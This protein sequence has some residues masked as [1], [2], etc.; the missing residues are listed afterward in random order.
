MK[1]ISPKVLMINTAD[2]RGGAASAA[3]DLGQKLKQSGWTIKW[4]VRTKDS[5]S[6]DVESI[7][8]PLETFFNRLRSFVL[9]D[10]INYGVSSKIIDHSWYRQANIVHFHNLHGNYLRLSLIADISREKP[11]I[12]T[13]HDMWAVTGKDPYLYPKSKNIF[14]YPP[15]LWPNK[16]KLLQ[17]KRFIYKQLANLTIVTPSY[18]L[19][20]EVINSKVFPDYIP[21]YTIHNGVD[22]DL[23]KPAESN[24]IRDNFSISKSKRIILF[25]AQGGFSNKRKGGDI[26]FQMLKFLNKRKDVF[27]VVVG[28][29]KFK[30]IENLLE[31]PFTYDKQNLVKYFSSANLVIAPSLADNMPLA[32]LEAMACGTPVITFKVGGIPEIITHKKTGYLAEYN[33]IEDFFY[34][35]NFMLNLAN[36]ELNL[37]SRR[38]RK[39]IVE[40]FNLDV[41]TKKYELLYNQLMFSKIK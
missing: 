32:I 36:Q 21:I 33:D 38:I 17:K 14:S 4:L 5:V 24:Y 3:W 11:T 26:A 40:K 41:T 10:D 28:G 25:V 15:M 20:N 31:I 29:K 27:W 37:M 6:S 16:D 1:P 8:S 18:W 19:Q 7:Q 23:Y 12:W 2:I 39:L 22:V 30:R 9:S 35:L 34:G 13:L